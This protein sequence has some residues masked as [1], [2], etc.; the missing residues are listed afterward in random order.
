MK[1]PWLMGEV[2]VPEVE[3]IGAAITMAAM[4]V[5]LGLT[6][7]RV[8]CPKQGSQPRQAAFTARMEP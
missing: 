1:P 4:L 5:T 3:G 6:Q 2:G 7:S 8:R